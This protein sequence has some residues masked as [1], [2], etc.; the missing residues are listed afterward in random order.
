MPSSIRANPVTSQGEILHTDSQLY[1]QAVAIMQVL[2]GL[3]VVLS[4]AQ[5]NSLTT[6]AN[7]ISKLADIVTEVKDLQT[8]IQTFNQSLS[9]INTTGFASLNQS[10]TANSNTGLQQ[11]LT[12]INTKVTS[13]ETIVSGYSDEFSLIKDYSTSIATLTTKSTEIKTAIDKLTAIL[14]PP[15]SMV[16][17]TL[18]LVSAASQYSISIPVGTKKISFGCRGDRTLNDIVADIRYSMDTNQVFPIATNSN[19][20]VLSASFTEEFELTVDV[21]KTIYFASSTAGTKVLFRRWS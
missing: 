2:G 3:E 5:G 9:T 13:L 18:D 15:S 19:Y 21:A 1:V 7:S 17:Q 11:T 6:I 20:G 8:K 14:T 16:C 10:I 12:A 4:T